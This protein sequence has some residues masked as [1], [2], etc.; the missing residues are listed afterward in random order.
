M[1]KVLITPTT[2]TSGGGPHVDLLSQAGFE[3]VYPRHSRQLTEEDLLAELPGV[4]ATLAG[5]EPYT[6]RVLAANKSLRVIARA[7]VGYDAV[8]LPAATACGVAVAITPGANHDAVAE[9]TWAMLLGAAK[10]MALLDRTTRAGQ[11][12]R[13]PTLAMRGCTLGII[14]L[15][16]IGK[17]VALRA[18]PFQMKVLAF[19]PFPDR[20]FVAQN[21]IELAPLER[22]LRESDYVTLHLP[23][24]NSTQYLMNANTIALMKPSAWLINTARGGLICEA[25]LLRALQQKQV[26]GAALDVFELEPPGDSPLFA[27]DNVLLTPHIAGIDEVSRI[28]L[29]VHAARA[30]V[31]LSR[32]EWPAEQIVNTD[33]KSTFRW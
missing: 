6:P 20:T 21:N 28:E 18:P 26:A 31:A 32:G 27:L 10:R 11:W 12:V 2:L 33:V 14:G 17:S 30:I 5:S 4:V 7:G 29:G 24:S 15:G 8:D 16:R 23:L 13:T 9:H 3:V 22:V 25:D 19:E 1:P